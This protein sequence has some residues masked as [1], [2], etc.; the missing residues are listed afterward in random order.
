MLAITLT[1]PPHCSQVSIS[2]PK[3]RLSRLLGD[4]GNPE[5]LN[6]YAYVVNNPATL[7][8]P[9]GFHA[10]YNDCTVV[11]DAASG[12][13]EV[14]VTVRI[15]GTVVGSFTYKTEGG[16]GSGSSSGGTG[17]D[18]SGMEEVTV[19]WQERFNLWLGNGPVFRALDVIGQ[20]STAYASLPFEVHGGPNINNPM[21]GSIPIELGVF[22]LSAG[23]PEA[24]LIGPAAKGVSK[25]GG[26]VIGKMDDL[27]KATG[28]RIGDHTLNLPKL[29]PGPGQWAQ[30]ERELLDAMSTGRPIRDVSPTQGG[31][32]LERERNLLIDPGWRFDPQ[33]Y[34]WSPGR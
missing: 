6:R 27:A 13:R 17:R 23:F 20:G 4:I 8:D 14:T 10:C 32:F 21:L 18:A 31:G 9:T 1:L 28:W 19:G 3:T 12:G 29:P 30:N 11:Y 2:M 7:T 5:T 25:A 16:G 22:F 24:R 33:T 15:G 34:L 26:L